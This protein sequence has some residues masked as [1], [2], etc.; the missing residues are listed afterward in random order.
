MYENPVLQTAMP[1]AGAAMVG[2]GYFWM[3]MTLIGI[4]MVAFGLYKLFTSEQEHHA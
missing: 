3:G 1:V 2:M 4:A